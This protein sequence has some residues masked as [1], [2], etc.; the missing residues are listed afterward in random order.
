MPGFPREQV[1]VAIVAIAQTILRQWILNAY[2]TTDPEPYESVLASGTFQLATPSMKLSSTVNSP[3]T[4][5]TFRARFRRSA[6]GWRGSKLA[7]LRIDEALKEIHAVA[8]KDPLAAAEGAVLFLE[9]LSPALADVD[10]SSGALGQAASSAVQAL[11]PLIA[12]APVDTDIRDKW[13]E[14]LFAAIQV[15]DPPYIESLGDHWGTICAEPELASRWADELMPGLRRVLEDTQRGGFGY[16]SG[17]SL[18]YSALFKAGRHDELL[19]LLALDP[20][21]IWP[22]L[23]WGGR[24]RLARGQ[25][26]EAIAYVKA[27]AEG[28]TTEETLAR[29]AEEALLQAGRRGE[30]YERYA[31]LANRATAYLSTYRAVAKKYPEV[32]SDRLFRDLVASTPGEPGKWFATAKTLK[33]F[34]Q[35][36]KLAWA[37]PCDPKTLTRAARDHCA[38]QPAFATEC[39]LAALHWMSLGYGYELTVLD[40]R[41][42]HRLAIEAAQ[43]CD[44]VDQSKLRLQQVLVGDQARTAW[45]RLALGI[46]TTQVGG[47]RRK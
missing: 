2:Q 33:L 22:Y 7:V 17:T 20:H 8:R 28:S 23:V 25:I 19:E 21:P 46:K 15:D 14:R 27:A 38:G 36:A 30:A 24:V 29:F 16:F 18:C 39:A 32:A 34:D 11:V 10:S 40:V 26:D 37:S 35:A 31:I 6:F 12:Q 44:A 3:V 43:R 13:L 9:R 1:L 5:W 41:D 4:A 42:A 45:M 47:D